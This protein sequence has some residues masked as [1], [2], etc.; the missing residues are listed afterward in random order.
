MKSN[1]NNNFTF[2]RSWLQNIGMILTL[3]ALGGGGQFDPP[4][5]IF[6]ALK[7]CSLTDCQKFGTT[8]PCF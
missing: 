3:E 4:P 6:L 5:S 2:M 7:F 8:V 1:K